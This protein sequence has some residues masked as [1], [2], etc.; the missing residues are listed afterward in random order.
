MA[1]VNIGDVIDLAGTIKDVLDKE[2]D[3]KST[4]LEPHDVQSITNQVTTA[5][6]NEVNPILVNATNNEPFYQSRIFWGT[7]VAMAAPLIG[8][9]LPALNVIPQDQLVN[10]GVAVGTAIGGIY[11]L[12]SRFGGPKKPLGE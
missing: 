12:L 5:V 8:L 1:R 11:T 4:S 7:I 9:A 6:K 10:V 2:A 3:K